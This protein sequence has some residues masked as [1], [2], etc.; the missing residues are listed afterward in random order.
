MSRP[1]SLGRKRWEVRLAVPGT[2]ISRLP[3]INPILLQ[4]LF[5][6]ELKDEKQIESFLEGYYLESVDPFLL[7]D[8]DKA[9]HR[10]RQAIDN[11]EMIV[12]YGDFDADGVTAT[13][14]LVQA[15]RGLGIE[16]RQAQPYIPDRVDEGYGLNEE[17]LLGLKEKGAGLVIAVDCGIRAIEEVEEANNIGLDVIIADHHR[18]GPELPPAFAV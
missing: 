12:V 3:H 18:L 11:D 10:I 13:V 6:R 5:N 7:K 14:L 9:V 16:R 17:A 1:E 15:L 8:M 4:I 2:L